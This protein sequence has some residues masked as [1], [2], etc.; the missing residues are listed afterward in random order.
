MGKQIYLFSL[1]SAL[2]D[3]RRTISCCSLGISDVCSNKASFTFVGWP[4][5][6]HHKGFPKCPL[7]NKLLCSWEAASSHS[8]F[9][10]SGAWVQ[11]LRRKG[12]L[13]H[14]GTGL[15][16]FVWLLLNKLAKSFTSLFFF[17]VLSCLL[18]RLC[19]TFQ[20]A[21]LRCSI[22]SSFWVIPENQPCRMFL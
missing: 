2:C 5:T 16:G 11:A 7:S 10:A 3:R 6:R 4:F 13:P 9:P 17:C 1:G 20:T 15:L 14:P 8:I 19:T 18:A 12:E 21:V 22:S